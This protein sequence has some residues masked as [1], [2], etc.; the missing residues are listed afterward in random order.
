MIIEYRGPFI[1]ITFIPNEL[2][3]GHPKVQLEPGYTYERIFI[4]GLSNIT[5]LLPYQQ[6]HAGDRI[7][8]PP[9]NSKSPSVLHL[10]IPD[11][12]KRA[13]IKFTIE[14]FGQIP[15]EHYFDEAFKPIVVTGDDGNNYPVIPSDQFK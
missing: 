14:K 9:V 2:K 1:H 13:D 5:E 7:T 6:V 4:H 8:F 11:V 10:Y 3:E 12:S 15:D